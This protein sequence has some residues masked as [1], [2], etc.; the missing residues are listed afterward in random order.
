MSY[1]LD[2]LRKAEAQ[3]DRQRVPGLHDQ[4]ASAPA[5]ASAS[6]QALLWGVLAIG[7]VSVGLAAWQLWPA[8]DAEPA[9]PVASVQPQPT[10]AP[11][12]PAVAPAPAPAPAAPP[13][14]AAVQPA[15]PPVVETAPPRPAPAPA[16]A[17]VRAEPPPAPP[18]AVAATPP[19]PPVTSA[20]VAPPASAPAAAQAILAEAPPDAPRIAISG[21]V[22]SQ[23]AAQRML[24]VNGQVFNEG[25]EVAPGLVL[26]QIRPN[27]AVLRWRG[28]RYS[29]RY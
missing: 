19:A 7:L 22:Y 28:Q 10:R 25:A 2:A 29:L 9:A 18:P 3:R 21:G 6:P 12:P 15:P 5:S 26:E 8:N 20:P 27:Q 13:V 16:R 1:I 11:A 24:V 17:P 14:A 23:D 4:P